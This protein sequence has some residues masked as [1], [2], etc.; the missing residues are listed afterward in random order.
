M[1]AFT[2]ARP[3]KAE[4]H[5]ALVKAQRGS[6][7]TVRKGSKPVTGSSRALL[8]RGL[9]PALATLTIESEGKL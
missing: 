2:D 6:S 5:A 4:Y 9:A 1:A 3:S 8:T 7:P